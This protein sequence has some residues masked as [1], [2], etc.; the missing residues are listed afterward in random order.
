MR[1]DPA[2]GALAPPSLA[3]GMGMMGNSAISLWSGAAQLERNGTACDGGTDG[4]FRGGVV[5]R[6]R[7]ALWAQFKQ[8]STHPPPVLHCGPPLLKNSLAA[9]SRSCPANWEG[10][11]TYT[12]AEAAM[13]PPGYGVTTMRRG[14]YDDAALSL[15]PVSI[16]LAPGGRETKKGC[17]LGVNMHLKCPYSS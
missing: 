17:L 12:G 8:E 13:K 16:Q 5:G 1:L 10:A 14:S 9:I 6:I 7:L 2:L 15:R 11:D 4:F 3:R